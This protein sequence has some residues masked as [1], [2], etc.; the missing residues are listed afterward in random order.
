MCG[1]SIVRTAVIERFLSRSRTRHHATLKSAGVR[2]MN[3]EKKACS[4]HQ[5]AD[6]LPCR[7]KH[8]ICIASSMCGFT[9]SPHLQAHPFFRIRHLDFPSTVRQSRSP[10]RLLSS[11]DKFEIG[12]P[13]PSR[14]MQK[15]CL[16]HKKGR[17]EMFYNAC[18]ERLDSPCMLLLLRSGW[19]LAVESEE[20]IMD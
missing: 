4:T 11:D 10:A 6:G 16:S 13:S 20:E 17:R 9:P 18:P 15:R 3:E 19:T 12:I 1:Q 7:R 5:D 8:S 2:D 14:S